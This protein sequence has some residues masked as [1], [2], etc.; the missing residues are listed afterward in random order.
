MFTQLPEQLDPWRSAERGL[1]LK[2]AVPLGDL[3]R[4]RDLLLVA[5]GEAAYQIRFEPDPRGRALILGTVTAELVLEC[6]RCLGPLSLPVSAELRLIAVR[7]LKE[8]RALEDPFE[9][10]LVEEGVCRPLELIEEELLLARPHI[11]L[12]SE[13]ACQAPEP[14]GEIA[15]APER[16]VEPGSE[17]PSP[18]AVLADLKAHTKH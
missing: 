11:P 13:E 4:L 9:P 1:C 7:G 2:G 10:L 12:H 3:P 17:P 6:Q 8:A 14:L 18:F 16:L 15:V 5:E